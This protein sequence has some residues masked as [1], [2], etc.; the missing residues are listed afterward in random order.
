MSAR[1][2][3]EILKYWLVIF[4][5]V[6]FSWKHFILFAVQCLFVQC[7]GMLCLYCAVLYLCLYYTVMCSDLPKVLMLSFTTALLLQSAIQSLCHCYR[8]PT[9]GT[10]DTGHCIVQLSQSCFKT[11]HI[12][13]VLQ[14]HNF[15]LFILCF[16][17]F[18]VFFWSFFSV[19]HA[20]NYLSC[21]F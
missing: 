9:I 16:H 18:E 11:F 17:Q 15:T 5:H 2:N 13:T 20:V 4:L 10:T 14:F 21:V 1:P 7:W 12:F 8:A 6:C 19:V 3:L